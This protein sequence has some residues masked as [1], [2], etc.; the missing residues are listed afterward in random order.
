[1]A[2]VVTIVIL[3]IL[4]TISV[5]IVLNGALA[6]RTQRGKEMHELEREKERL[7]L[8]KADVASN[9]N[10][11]GKVTV[12]TY[13]EE[14]INQRITTT[15]EITDN[16]EGSKT[17][18]T[19]TNYNVLIEPNGENDVKI[20][21]DG[22][23]GALLPRIKN[24][25]TEVVE[26][27]KIKITVEAIRADKYKYEYKID[28]GNEESGWI[29]I[30]DNSTSTTV[31]TPTLNEEEKYMIRVTITGENGTATQ[32]VKIANIRKETYTVK[33]TDG[34]DGAV[35]G[36]V[37]C[38]SL[39]K[40]SDTPGFGKNPTRKGYT[41]TGWAPAISEKVTEDVT[42]TATWRKNTYTVTYTD[43][44]TGEI[45][46]DDQVYEDLEED[47]D[48]PEFEGT[49]SREGYTFEGWAPAIDGKVTED[50]TYTATWSK[51]T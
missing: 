35:F 48:T 8:I 13:I 28:D 36:D 7:E 16:G 18:I 30:E 46:F 47:S 33:Y 5:N 11:L 1:M 6:N 9:R 10:Y 32:I 40:G 21:I 38:G 12:D 44:V 20:T 37:E 43:G 29:T 51:N 39:E 31:T 22:K 42:Y 26:T 17:V 4:A 49:P 2:L 19:D 14:L 25:K 3:I 50:V 24:V 34:L 41:F 27:A 45:V 23:V 15:E